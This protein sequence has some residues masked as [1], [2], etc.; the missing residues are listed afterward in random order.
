MEQPRLTIYST[1]DTFFV[2]GNI[3]YCDHFGKNKLGIVNIV[4]NEAE[5]YEIININDSDVL[6]KR[7]F[8]SQE[9]IS[10][11]IINTALRVVFTHTETEKLVLEENVIDRVRLAILKEIQSY[12]ENTKLKENVRQKIENVR[13]KKDNIVPPIA[14]NPQKT[15]KW[16][17]GIDLQQSQTVSDET[18]QNRLLYM[19]TNSYPIT[20]CETEDAG[21]GCP[22]QGG[23]R[24]KSRRYKKTNRRRRKKSSNKSNRRRTRHHKKH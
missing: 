4:Q 20:D 5:S 21:L 18:T 1:S 6:N 22:V 7:S 23:R 8:T 16:L 9:I 17:Q 15:E 12:S 19:L 13:Q 14:N 10:N 24:R 11:E 2:E 3:V